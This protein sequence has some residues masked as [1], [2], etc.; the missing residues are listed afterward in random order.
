MAFKLN[1]LP[2]G[3]AALFAIILIILA[4]I[5]ASAA[6]TTAAANSATTTLKIKVPWDH[7]YLCWTYP[8]DPFVNSGIGPAKEWKYLPP[9]R[10]KGKEG[11]ID[12]PAFPFPFNSQFT[13]VVYDIPSGNEAVESI[14]A[15]DISKGL[16]LL[17]RDFDEVRRVRIKVTADHGKP[18]ESAI[19]KLNA[20]TGGQGIVII[21]PTTVGVAEFTDVTS[22]DA[23]VDVLYGDGKKASQTITIPDE[24]DEPVFTTE[25]PVAGQVETV[26]ETAPSE[27]G[28]K[29]AKREKAHKS[30]ADFAA[31]L[32]G[33]ILGFLILAGIVVGIYFYLKSKGVTIESGLKKMGVE[34]PEGM[35][36]NQPAAAAPPVE[37]VDP[38]VCQFCGQRKDAQGNCA[39]TIG[40]T[41]TQS[42]ASTGPRLIATQGSYAMSIFELTSD[43]TTLGREMDNTIPL[44]NDTTVSRHHARIAREAGG[45][46]VYDAGSSN[47]VFVNGDKVAQKAIQPGDEIQVGSTR[48]RFEM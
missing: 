13:V 26:K 45:Y 38:N 11:M 37:T 32:L 39:C 2:A 12:L 36:P 48:F 27:T 8:T 20:I 1:K 24:R 28:V 35:S 29:T 14:K 15:R 25:F 4:A 47:G 6:K 3:I 19:V 9:A 42:G 40:A 23:T 41:P 5:P 22:G 43:I 17:K 21:D 46:V 33:T 30:G 7:A 44:P 31:T 18:I 10:F 34:L 16:T